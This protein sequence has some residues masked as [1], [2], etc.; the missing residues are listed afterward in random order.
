MVE[1]NQN[2]S[3][4]SARL[5]LSIAEGLAWRR[6]KAAEPCTYSPSQTSLMNRHMAS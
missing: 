2:K 5:H 4:N 6:A 3:E 1:V